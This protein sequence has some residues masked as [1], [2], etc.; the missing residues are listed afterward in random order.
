MQPMIVLLKARALTIS[1]VPM[2]SLDPVDIHL[3]EGVSVSYK[4]QM[5]LVLCKAGRFSLE[6]LPSRSLTEAL[7]TLVVRQ[8]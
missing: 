4:L 8:T 1:F 7:V 2:L 6:D 5:G 3:T